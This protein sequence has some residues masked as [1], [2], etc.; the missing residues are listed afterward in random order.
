MVRL[1]RVTGRG[2]AKSQGEAKPTRTMWQTIPPVRGRDSARRGSVDARAVSALTAAA[3]FFFA[4][5]LRHLA[6]PLYSSLHDRAGS[7]CEVW[8]KPRPLPYDI[9]Q[10][11]V[12]RLHVRCFLPFCRS[13]TARRP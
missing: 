1:G 2:N 7:T 5:L 12:K 11:V 8:D 9:L 10:N 3:K 13:G 6:A 4:P